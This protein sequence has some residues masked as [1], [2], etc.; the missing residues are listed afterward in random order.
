MGSSC[1]HCGIGSETWTLKPGLESL[2]GLCK[3]LLLPGCH[4]VCCDPG[5]LP[6]TQAAAAGLSWEVLLVWTAP[7][8]RAFVS[9]PPRLSAS[10]LDKVSSS[11]HNCIMHHAIGPTRYGF[12]GGGC[13]QTAWPSCAGVVASTTQTPSR[14]NSGVSS[15][16]TK[17]RWCG[18]SLSSQFI[19]PRVCACAHSPGKT[20]QRRLGHLGPQVHNTQHPSTTYMRT[21]VTRSANSSK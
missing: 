4:L 5:K 15:T 7:R 11:L 10:V 3:I 2:T 20:W 17:V 21:R 13:F 14:I 8:V 12:A 9:V 16:T 18:N 1:P 19:R 6:D